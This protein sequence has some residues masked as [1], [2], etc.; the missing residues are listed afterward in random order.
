MEKLRKYTRQELLALGVSLNIG[1]A[2]NFAE[3]CKK[4]LHYFTLNKE[5]YVGPFRTYKKA[6]KEYNIW[7]TEFNE[8]YKAP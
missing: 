8:I 3:D 5:I 4:G 1:Y 7:I 6:K 2:D